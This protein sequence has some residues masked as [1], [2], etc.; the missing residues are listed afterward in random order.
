MVSC[1]AAYGG[2]FILTKQKKALFKGI[3]LADS[4]VIDLIKAYFYPMA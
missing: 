1:D 2:F 4:L 3:E